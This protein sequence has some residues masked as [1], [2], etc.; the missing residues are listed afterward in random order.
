MAIEAKRGCGYRKINGL[1]LCGGV[2]SVGCDR[3][4]YELHNCPVCGS[5]IKFTRGFTWIEAHKMFGIHKGCLDPHKPCWMCQPKEGEMFGLLWVGESFY[6]PKHFLKEA[7]E[8]GISKR[9]PFIPKELV[10]GKTVILLAH[11][12]ASTRLP[13]PE[14][15]DAQKYEV[16]NATN[17][18]LFKVAVVP[19]ECSGIFCAFIPKA[20]EMPIWESELTDEKKEELL[21]RGIAPIPIP[22]GDVDHSDEKATTAYD[23]A[24]KTFSK[25]LLEE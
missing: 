22:D 21:K 11:K 8:M 23:P 25:I 2:L 20:V 17:G 4:P 6:T 10:L 14:E 1:Y 13:T 15:M 12:K 7:R 3:L 24:T 18:R 16:P 9:I 5:G 19:K